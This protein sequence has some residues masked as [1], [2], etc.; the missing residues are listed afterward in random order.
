[1][2]VMI[3]PNVS[4]ILVVVLQVHLVQL[5][6]SYATH[7]AAV[8]GWVVAKAAKSVAEA[9]APLAPIAVLVLHLEPI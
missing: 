3:M 8:V 5:Q 7:N 9:V 2:V 6:H 4:V 1:M